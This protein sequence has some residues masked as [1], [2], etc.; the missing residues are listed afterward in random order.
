MILY[1]LVIFLSIC[2]AV[3]A[4]KNNN[5]RW[6]FGVIVLLSLLAGFR[7]YS[8]GTDTYTYYRTFMNIANGGLSILEVGFVMVS[9][10]L[11]MLFGDARALFVIYAFV[12]NGLIIRRLW[13][14]R[15]YCS[16]GFMCF[17]YVTMFF[18]QTMNIMRQYIALAIVFFATRYIYNRKYIWFILGVLLASILH[19]SALVSIFLI[20][21][22]YYFNG[23]GITKKKVALTMILIACIP[24]INRGIIYLYNVYDRYFGEAS[25]GL[26]L[27]SL[28]R[29]GTIIVFA[30]LAINYK[31]YFWNKKIPKREF[32]IV[33]LIYIISVGIT[34]IGNIYEYVGRVS[35]YFIMFEIV[36]AAMLARYEKNKKFKLFSM[37]YVFLAL[38]FLIIKTGYLG[39]NGIM[40]FSISL[41]E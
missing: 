40:P 13:D 15:E 24:I 5:I 16:F 20:I 32:R 26:S 7:D 12:I 38:Y 9:R 41:F 27:L 31:N 25:I 23:R 22:N 33:T 17:L 19:T 29:I 34:I 39:E 30:F 14:F 28:L 35:I 1:Y 3:R 10:F 36:F 37:I 11:M 21:P 2:I 18:P 6:V 8:V 4:E